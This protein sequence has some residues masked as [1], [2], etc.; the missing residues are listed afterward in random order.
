MLK[1]EFNYTAN[2]F[3]VSIKRKN[4]FNNAS[5]LPQLCLKIGVEPDD[6]RNKTGLQPERNS[7]TRMKPSSLGKQPRS[8]FWTWSQ[9]GHYK[10]TTFRFS[11]MNGS[12]FEPMIDHFGRMLRGCVPDS[13]SQRFEFS[14]ING[15][16]FELILGS[17]WSRK[18]CGCVPDS[19][20]LRFQV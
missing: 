7:A 19:V 8:I 17:F 15:S 6:S 18:L 20:S 13:V 1:N 3:Q 10:V 16:S 4:G 5:C 14:F 9:R 12:S 2:R 11:F